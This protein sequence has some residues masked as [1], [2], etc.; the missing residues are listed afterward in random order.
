MPKEVLA[1]SSIFENVFVILITMMDS[2]LLPFD[3]KM[4]SD[5]CILNIHLRVIMTVD[6]TS[7]RV[8]PIEQKKTMPE[9]S[10]NGFHDAAE[11]PSSTDNSSSQ[12]V[13]LDE[14]SEMSQ[15]LVASTNR[16]LLPT[17][18]TDPD[19]RAKVIK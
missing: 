17:Q 11:R 6:N 12:S 19:K 1:V 4:F 3:I 14:N 18:T 13:T 8:K 16:L 9:L 15:V 10:S 5:V 7:E 2:F